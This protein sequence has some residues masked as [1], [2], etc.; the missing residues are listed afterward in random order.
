MWSSTQGLVSDTTTAQISST[1]RAYIDG[2]RSLCAREQARQTSGKPRGW[3]DI[4]VVPVSKN[5]IR[6]GHR[7]ALQLQLHWG[8]C[9]D[10][11]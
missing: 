8:P 2:T 4:A 6:A 7:T 3:R 5:E 11:V 1:T 10:F 9:L